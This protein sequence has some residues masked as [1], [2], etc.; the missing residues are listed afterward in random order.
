MDGRPLRDRSIDPAELLRG[1]LE[2]IVFFECRLGQ[3]E[4]ELR[5]A[6]DLAAREKEGSGAARARAVELETALLQARSD[7]SAASARNAELDERVRLLESERERFLSGLIDHA[8]IVNAPRGGAAGA[9]RA[10]AGGVPG[11]EPDGDEADGPDLAGFIAELRGEIE[12]LR[13]WKAA[14]EKAGIRIDDE[15]RP[16]VRQLG[17]GAHAAVGAVAAR[18]EAAG[19]L[20]V[21]PD[22]AARSA[23][24]MPSRAER[25]L[26]ETSMDDL[27]SS[28]P[29]TRKRAAACLAALGSKAATPLVAA[30]L[31]RERD[32]EA[33]SALLSA[34]AALGE[35]ASADLVVRELAD[36]RPAVRAAALDAIAALA[37]DA[38]EPHLARALADGSPLVRRRAVLLLG[39]AKGERAEDALASALADR[40]ASVARAAALALSGRPT[41]RAQGALAKA[42]DHREAGVRRAAAEAVGRW[43]GE[44]V[45]A[46][47]SPAERRRAGRRIADKLAAVDASAL[48]DAVVAG[49][50]AR[51][52]QAVPAA[53]AP[54]PR[55][56]APARAAAVPSRAAAPARAAIANPASAASPIPPAAPAPSPASHAPAAAAL[57]HARSAVAVLDP[58]AEGGD[59]LEEAI[60]VEVRSALRG[61]TPDELAAAL[62]TG[63]AAVE[64]AVNALVA[65]GTLAQRGPRFFMS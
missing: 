27:S 48:R 59:P 30:A 40:D 52:A 7:L 16:T 55:A 31:G 17:E 53:T 44:P 45:D 57:S 18:F 9:P 26:Y 41:V 61:R 8:R 22:E 33:K 3:M 32:A 58:P 14:A 1:A 21:A 20:G 46:A 37:R 6:R 43:A 50:P 4:A 2:K 42:L 35:P 38:A 11:G 12:R 19:R 34:L 36:P 13:P 5:A 10:G 23:A 39:F 15:P 47:A 54:V 62:S 51:P 65:R 25:S 29:G 28:D 24:R 64:A 60:V 63:T 56:A 49:A